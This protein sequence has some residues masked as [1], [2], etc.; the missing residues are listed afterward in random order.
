MIS[1]SNFSSLVGDYREQTPV[2]QI[3]VLRK[4]YGKLVAVQNASFT[5]YPQQVFCLVGPNGAGK[6]LS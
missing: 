3:N 1:T 5:V 4:S 2:L 6:T